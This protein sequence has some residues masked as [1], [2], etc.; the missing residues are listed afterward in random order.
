MRE[1]AKKMNVSNL[2]SNQ[3]AQ[4]QS[5]EVR[6]AKVA[7]TNVALWVVCWTPYAAIVVQGLFFNQGPI[8]PLVTMLPAFW[9]SLPPATTPWSMPS[10]ILSSDC[11]INWLSI[12]PSQALQKQMPWFCIHENNETSSSQSADTKSVE[13]KE[14][15]EDA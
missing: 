14:A 10:T 15:K 12:S 5:A 11:T 3:E 7:C 13:T 6:I 1:Q 9:Q 8:T 4:A 2:R